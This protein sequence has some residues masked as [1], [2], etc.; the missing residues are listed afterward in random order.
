MQ[1]VVSNNSQV[2]RSSTAGAPANAINENYF[3][4]IYFKDP[5]AKKMMLILL[6][7]FMLEEKKNEA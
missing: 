7:E 3:C 5:S 6:S 2:L 4:N 1:L